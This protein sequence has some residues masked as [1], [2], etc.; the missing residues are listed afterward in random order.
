MRPNIFCEYLNPYGLQVMLVYKLFGILLQLALGVMCF[1]LVIQNTSS[2]VIVVDV[3]VRVLVEKIVD[4]FRA[5]SKLGNSKK[6]R[7]EHL[8][9][10]K[11][12]LRMNPNFF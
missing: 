12:L 9:S 8:E 11:S 4:I 1:Y 10:P 2:V 3:F 6:L 7:F 5:C